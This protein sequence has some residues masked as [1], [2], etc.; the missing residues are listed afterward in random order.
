VIT[1][2][3]QRVIHISSEAP[4]T[5]ELMSTQIFGGG[6]RNLSGLDGYDGVVQHYVSPD[7]QWFVFVVLLHN[8]SGEKI[9]YQLRASDGTEPPPVFR[10]HLPLVRQ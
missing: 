1:P 6:L 10:T 3:S 5:N 9:G 7:G 4:D 2:D 8:G